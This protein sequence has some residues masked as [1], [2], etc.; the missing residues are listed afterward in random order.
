MPV[1]QW[2]SA[3]STR[4]KASQQQGGLSCY[5]TLPRVHHRAQHTRGVKEM[6]SVNDSPTKWLILGSLHPWHSLI[7]LYELGPQ[8]LWVPMLCRTLNCGLGG[9]TGS[10]RRKGTQSGPGQIP[11]FYKSKNQD[12]GLVM[13]SHGRRDIPW[14]L[15]DPSLS[16][17]LA[18][19]FW[20]LL[21]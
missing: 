19:G 21:Q 5:Q 16:S 3:C 14:C 9:C 6:S 13:S 20:N 2:F 15:E 11:A 1:A 8:A 7:L 10:W 4:L 17:S 12:P 18:P